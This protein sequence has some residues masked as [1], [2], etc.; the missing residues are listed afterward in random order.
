MS[1]RPL[2]LFS[3][4]NI[5]RSADVSI[6]GGSGIGFDLGVPT[7]LQRPAFP[8]ERRTQFADT[9]SWMKSKHSFKFGVDIAH[10]NDLS[11]N[12]R[13][14]F[15]SFAYTT[16][17]NYLSDLLSPNKCG[18]A[19]HNTPCY[20]SYQQAFG[21]LGFQFNT[22][23][24]GFFA[25]DNWRILPRLTLNLGVRFDYEQ[26]PKPFLPNP[27]VLNTQKLP[28]DTNNWGP[29][30]GFAYDVFGDGKTSVRGG[31]G[32]YYGRIINSTVYNALINTGVTGGQFSFRFNAFPAT[33]PLSACEPQ[34]PQ[35]LPA[36]PTGACAGSALNIVFF[37]PQ[38]QAPAVHQTDLTVE[39]ELPWKT[40]VSVSYLGSFGRD[41]PDFV[42]TNINPAVAGSLTYNVGTG[43]PLAGPTYTS[44]LYKV[45][46]V[47]HARPN[48]AFGA[49][50]DIFSGIS[51]SY[52]ALALRVN[53]RFSQNFEI[54]YNYTWSHSLDFGQN[55]ST[56]S[57]TN[58]LLD[59]F[60]IRNEYG[61]SIFDVRQRSVLNAVIGT[62]WKK[63]G[64]LG[65]LVNGW[66]I[67]PLYQAQSGLPYSLTTAGSAPGGVSGGIN[68]SGG[69]YLCTGLLS[70]FLVDYLTFEEV[71]LY[72]Y[73]LFAERVGFKLGWGCIAFYPFFYAIPLWSTVDLPGANSSWGWMLFAAFV[74]FAGWI[75]SRGANLQK[76]Y[77]KKIPAKTFLGITPETMS[78]EN[79]ALLVNGFWGVSRH[80]NY[81]GE[82]LMAI[83]LV[84][85]TGYP[86][87]IW[88]WLYPLYYVVLLFPRQINDD[89]RCASKYGSLWNRYRERVP[90]R[91]I[92]FIY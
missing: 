17:G 1:R 87:L 43:G 4:F 91:I 13:I 34:F 40:A 68:G 20:S 35:I 74:F 9:V 12:L 2:L 90:Y 26:M 86:Q 29:R 36:Q 48:P 46:P 92:P 60:N 88:P 67:A 22:N 79:N 77:F 33:N 37:D 82:I 66:Q 31:Y 73:D 50:T 76:Y 23:D 38:F 80:I 85:S 3:D 44:V 18:G 78:D 72:T 14:Q 71:H 55:G 21:P 16:V 57:D 52:N 6:V 19:A 65:Y 64:A 47:T 89:K 49:M 42:D 7:F 54:N 28:S 15:G 10:S 30:I 63:E 41:L 27:N 83:G 25:E 32:I 70:F 84:L 56:F 81:L 69:I 39:R 45:D 58:D 24:V 53:K 11:E 61:N 5:G 8:D 62:P 75:L 59:P 51:S